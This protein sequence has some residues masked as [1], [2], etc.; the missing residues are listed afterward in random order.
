ML[1]PTPQRKSIYACFLP[2][3]SFGESEQPAPSL[4]CQPHQYR[5]AGRNAIAPLAGAIFEFCCTAKCNILSGSA[6]AGPFGEPSFA[7][8]NA[9]RRARPYRPRPVEVG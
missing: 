7:K 5:E 6:A 4:V 9:E 1:R 2:R 8:C 3:I